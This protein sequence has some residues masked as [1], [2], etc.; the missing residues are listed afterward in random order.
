MQKISPITIILIILAA[1]ILLFG[2]VFAYQNYFNLKQELQ[3]NETADWKTYTNIKNNYSFKYPNSVTLGS[4]I[5]HGEQ[6]LITNDANP[7]QAHM[8]TKEFVFTVSASPSDQFYPF[9]DYI[10][11]TFGSMPKESISTV[12]VKIAGTDGHKVVFHNVNGVVSDFYFIEKSG[13]IFELTVLK[14][15]SIAGQIFS[16]FKFTK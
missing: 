8:T 2:G 11:R 9:P 15:N 5:G 6:S 1:A 10:T 12:S 14:N 13:Q 16:T 4:M 3:N 7:V